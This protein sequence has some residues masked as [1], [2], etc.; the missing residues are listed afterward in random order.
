[1][2]SF[3]GSRALPHLTYHGPTT[4][5]EMLHLLNVLPGETKIIAGGTD[6]LPAVRMGGAFYEPGLNIVDVTQVEEIGN[7]QKDGPTISIGAATR[8]SVVSGSS[9]IKEGAPLLRMAIN[10]MGSAQVRNAGT[11]GGNLCTASPA[12]D[13]APPLLALDAQVSIKGPDKQVVIPLDQFFH[14]PGKTVLEPKDVLTE[15]QFKA[16]SPDE[17][18]FWY[19]MGRRNSFCIS[20]ISIALRL[21]VS[22]GV[23]EMVRIAL[24][25]VAPTPIRA[26]EAEEFLTDREAN[27]EVIE[28][29]A[30]LIAAATNPISDVR[31][32][33]EYRKDMAY[34]LGK[35]ALTA[36]QALG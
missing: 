13:T 11:V 36:C 4:L 18:H 16:M 23:F 30:R 27:A 2:K 17:T 1:M 10:D 20:V 26:I 32:T 28:K 19:K 33:G 29:G 8:L 15:I 9:A 5:D 22:D 7:I 31:A 21:I 12:G 14:G 3:I 35:R 6:F 34:V 24:G 25:A